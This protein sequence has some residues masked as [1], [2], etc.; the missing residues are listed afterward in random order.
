MDCSLPGSSV[1]GILQVRI[2]EWVAI[3]F[4]RGSSRPRK[5][6]AL[7]IWTY[8]GKVM[9]LFFNT[10]SIFINSFSSK[11]QASF[12]FMAA[13]TFCNDPGAKKIKSVIVAVVFPSVCHEL[14][15][16]GAMI[17]VFLNVEF[18]APFFT[19]LF[20]PYQKASLVPLHFLLLKWYI[21]CISEVVDISTG[22]PDASL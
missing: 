12:N 3:F 1:H 5:N 11:E 2:L 9:S 19:F 14:M 6:L 18:G 22:N 8:V 17:I 20:H 10:L 7:T 21:I 4:S 15:G 16:L 13:V